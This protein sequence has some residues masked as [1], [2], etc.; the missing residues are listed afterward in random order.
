MN[1][2][3]I[4]GAK[5]AFERSI[6]GYK[7]YDD[8]DA[9]CFRSE[10]FSYVVITLLFGDCFKYPDEH[11]GRDLLASSFSNGSMYVIS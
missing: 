1:F 6:D 2:P 11:C 7:L 5:G 10:L 4:S 9:I 8:V 3:S